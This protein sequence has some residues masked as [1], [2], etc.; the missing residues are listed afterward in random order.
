[1]NMTSRE[2]VMNRIAEEL[3]KLILYGDKNGA[4]KFTPPTQEEAAEKFGLNKITTC[5]LCGK[6]L[7]LDKGDGF[8]ICRDCQY[9]TRYLDILKGDK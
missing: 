7:N 2:D 3:D 6:E 9:D 5:V 4:F 1:M 8:V